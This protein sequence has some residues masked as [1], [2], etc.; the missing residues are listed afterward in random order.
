[1]DSYFCPVVEVYYLQKFPWPKVPLEVCI[2]DKTATTLS[3]LHF[4]AGVIEPDEG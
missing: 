3:F 1:M 2:V 4:V